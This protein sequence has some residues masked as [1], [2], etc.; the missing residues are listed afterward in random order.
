MIFF[1]GH[2][3][4]GSKSTELRRIRN[5]LDGPNVYYVTLA[6]AARDLD[7][8]NLRY[9]DVLLHLAA[10]LT[11]R[12]EDDG[13]A[14]DPVHLGRLESWFDQRV[15]EETEIE[16]LTR[17]VKA[18]AQVA[19]GLPYLGKLLAEISTAF[20]TNATHKDV[21]RRTLKNYFSDFAD[22][23]NH[24]DASWN[25]RT[26]SS[27]PRSTR[28]PRAWSKRR[29]PNAP[30]ICS[31]TWRSWSTTTTTGAV[32]PWSG[33]LLPTATQDACSMKPAVNSRPPHWTLRSEQSGAFLRL[34]RLLNGR[35]SFTLCFLTYSD[36]VYRDEAAGFLE[37]RLSAQVRV[38]IDPEERIGTEV[39]FDRLSANPDTG[40]AQLLSG[41]L[42]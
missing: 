33:P 14:I 29:A 21:L 19:A 22:A 27:W 31:I 12:L 26:T 4:C 41:V 5:D 32:I 9:Q 8:N 15:Q 30:A 1:C 37:A 24:S 6:D 3:G 11:K 42:A 36:S 25:P 20:K 40:P 35:R 13:V 23:F 17:Q 34:Q 7:P 10:T 38:V 18:G 28:V 16:E 39:L 2:R